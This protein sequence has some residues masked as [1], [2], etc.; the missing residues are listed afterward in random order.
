MPRSRPLP[1]TPTLAQASV[2]DPGLCPKP[3]G[4]V[5]GRDWGRIRGPVPGE[6]G[7]GWWAGRARNQRGRFSYGVAPCRPL[8]WGHA[9]FPDAHTRRSAL[10]HERLDVYHLGRQLQRTVREAL[11]RVPAGK[12]Y[13]KLVDDIRRAARSVVH[14]V[15]EGADEFSPLEKAKFYRHAR[16]SA[17]EVAAGLDSLVDW[18][19]L[20]ERHTRASKWLV[21][22]INSMLTGMIRGQ[23]ARSRDES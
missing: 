23:E 20:T 3:P 7:A 9:W 18:G 16:R 22:R 8:L 14:N 12:G 17:A 6:G 2:S 15:T 21:H 1:Q 11:D 13:A 19:A 5:P 10:A 4:T